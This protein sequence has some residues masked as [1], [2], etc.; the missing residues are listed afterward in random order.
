MPAR[1][2]SAGE[3]NVCATPSRTNVPSSAG[4]TPVR[5]LTSVLLPAPFAP[6]SAWISPRETV[7]AADLRATTEPNLLARSRTSSRGVESF[8]VSGVASASV[9]TSMIRRSQNYPWERRRRKGKT[10]GASRLLFA[11]ALASLFLR[12]REVSVVLL[13][14]VDRIC[15]RDI[16]VVKRLQ[17]LH[18]FVS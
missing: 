2:A 6:M 7:S 1:R 3:R 11:W 16:R 9:S 5:I 15:G 17:L 4:N 14:A 13:G 18:V 12:G 10:A 8:I